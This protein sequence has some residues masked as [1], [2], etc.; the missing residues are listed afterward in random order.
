MRRSL[1]TAAAM[2]ATLT[3]AQDITDS[4]CVAGL[5]MLVARGTNEDP[6]PGA[7]GTLAERIADRID[8]SEIV[9][10]DYPATFTDPLYPQS[11]V[12]GTDAMREAV[13]NYTDSCPDG[14]IAVFGYSQG[15]HVASNVFCGGSDE[16]DEEERDDA[17]PKDLVEDSGELSLMVQNEA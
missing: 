14:K 10:L 12:E 4:S 16:E 5:F 7:L 11:V 13:R 8:D 3:S 15:A 2:A 6:G 9:A 1:T 17:L